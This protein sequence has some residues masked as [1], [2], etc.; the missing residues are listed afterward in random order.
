MQVLLEPSGRS[1]IWFS[2][3]NSHRAT[4]TCDLF[5]RMFN[6]FYFWHNMIGF[7]SYMLDMQA[8]ALAVGRLLPAP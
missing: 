4:P 8:D 3:E 6:A 1:R 7:N 5:G 2:H